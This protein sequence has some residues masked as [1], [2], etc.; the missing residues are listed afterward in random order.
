MATAGSRIVAAQVS[1]ERI[2]TNIRT[3]ASAAFTAETVVQQITVALVTG[4]TYKVTYKGPLQS[5]VAGDSARSRIR[6]T[7]LAGAQLQN[8]RVGIPN[9]TAGFSADV[10]CEFTASSTGN[11]TFV[12]TGERAT[13]TG[14]ITAGAAADAPAYLYVDY[15]RG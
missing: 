10:E 7:N 14:N 13:G 2:G 6:Q 4:R 5:S 8:Y 3:A 1:G 12:V 11:V 15:I 9:A